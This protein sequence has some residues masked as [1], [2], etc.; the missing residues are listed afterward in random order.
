[1]TMYLAKVPKGKNCFR[2]VI[3][4]SYE[5]RDGYH[6]RDLFD[7]GANPATF[8][9]CPGGNGFYI[10][11]VVE[12]TI[13]KNGVIVSQED[14]EPLFFPFLPFHIRRVIEGF[15]RSGRSSKENQEEIKL[16][17]FHRFDI[18][19][20]QYLKLGH[21]QMGQPKKIPSQFYSGLHRKSRDEIE[22]DFIAAEKILNPRELARYTYQIFELHRYFDA[23]FA[24]NHPEFLDQSQLDHFFVEALCNLNGDETYRRGGRTSDCLYPHLVRYVIMYFDNAFIPQDPFRSFLNDFMNRHRIYRSP[25]SVRVS[26][27]KAARLFGVTVEKLKKMDA[28]ELSRTYRKLAMTT[29]PDKGGD[30]KRFVDLSEAYNKLLRGK[31]RR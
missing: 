12:E 13:E 24:R 4:Q 10:D 17:S 29:H 22:Y 8:I 30:P 3:R 26:L 7:L 31:K 5:D 2:Y 11:P 28:S 19:R 6:S 15:D 20:L 25:K 16:D 27:E 23:A 1:M 21:V 14:L 18:H 9:L